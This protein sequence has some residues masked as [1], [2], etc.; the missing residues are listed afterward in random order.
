M[1]NLDISELV[2]SRRSHQHISLSFLFLL[3]FLFDLF[4]KLCAIKIYSIN[5]KPLQLMKNFFHIFMDRF[6]GEIPWVLDGKVSVIVHLTLYHP[7]KAIDNGKLRFSNRNLIFLHP[8][9]SKI[10][11]NPYLCAPFTVYAYCIKFRSERT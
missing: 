2:L 6:E 8:K 7:N 4:S 3:F 10:F 1:Q 5:P 9:L 11:I